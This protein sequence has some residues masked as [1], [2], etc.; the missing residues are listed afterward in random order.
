M[1]GKL[2]IV[3]ILVIILSFSQ[4]SAY[5]DEV[6]TTG[7]YTYKLKGNGTITILNFDWKKNTGDVYIPSMIDGYTVTAVGDGAFADGRTHSDKTVVVV[8]PATIATVG[9]KAFYNSCVSSINI[10]LSLQSIG[11]GAFAYC[12]ISQFSVEPGHGSFATIDGVLYNKKSKTLIAYPQ[13]INVAA[14]IPDGIVAIDDYAFSGITLG[15]SEFSN[16]SN[17]IQFNDM[18]PSSVIRIGSY[19]FADCTIYYA[20]EFDKTGNPLSKEAIL[21]PGGVNEIG[22]Y[23]FYNCL[24]SKGFYDSPEPKEMI[25]GEKIIAVG[26]H[27]FDSCQWFE[28][29]AYILYLTRQTEMK[30]IGDYAFAN[31]DVNSEALDMQ[32]V[33]FDL[34]NAVAS[35]GK[36]AFESTHWVSVTSLKNVYS[37]GEYAFANSSVYSTIQP[38]DYYLNEPYSLKIPGTL[39]T[40]ETGV[41]SSN[42]STGSNAIQ[43]LEIGN[44]ITHINSHA[45]SGLKNLREVNL[46]DGLVFIGSQAFAKCSNLAVLKIPSSVT[47]IDED[48]F[49]RTTITLN[50]ENGSYAAFWAQENG[51]GYKYSD[52]I[53]DDTSWLDD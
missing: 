45:F 48:A 10:P 21:L 37:I 52:I 31:S 33:V 24:F 42:I 51:F 32:K 11:K 4:L 22:D 12:A 3:C 18:I 13:A 14:I 49:D 15:V 1:R 30:Q 29:F 28:G 2:A 27:A 35:I 25:I 47:T 20:T 6:R 44:G 19:A 17:A 8:L 43:V 40:V 36:H 5:A 39:N 53:S 16:S 41:Y 46:P 9:E 23:A 34:P 38:N 50:V 7:Q 26:N